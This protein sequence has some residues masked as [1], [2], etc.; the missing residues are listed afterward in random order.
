MQAIQHENSWRDKAQHTWDAELHTSKHRHR[1]RNLY[2]Q[3]TQ[4]CLSSLVGTKRRNFETQ[5]YTNCYH[6]HR[7]EWRVK[8]SE[9]DALAQ[10]AK[11]WWDTESWASRC[12]ESG[13]SKE[14]EKI[15]QILEQ[16]TKCDGKRYKV[17]LVFS[18][19]KWHLLSEQFLF[20]KKPVDFVGVYPWNEIGVEEALSRLLRS[21]GWKRIRQNPEARRYRS[22]KF[23]KTLVCTTSLSSKS[24]QSRKSEASVQRSLWI[25][26]IFTQRQPLQ[27]WTYC[28]FWL[29]CSS[30]FE[31]TRLP[32]TLKWCC[33]KRYYRKI[34]TCSNFYDETI[35]MTLIRCMSMEHMASEQNVYQ[36]GLIMLW[37]KRQ[38]SVLSAEQA[39]GN[40]K[41]LWA[42]SAKRQNGLATAGKL[43]RLSTQQTCHRL[44][45]KSLKQSGLHRP[46]CE[47]NGTLT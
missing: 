47:H 26:W 35:R 4:T 12:N 25:Q 10:Q 9:N 15:L 24:E 13:N 8:G 28:R 27:D 33:S 22:Y 29:E 43:K 19:K 39:I 11:T 21:R 31:N 6:I 5:R 2:L 36:L 32:L 18:G 40:Y 14:D 37:N 44:L 34:V 1:N 41:S 20:Y 30:G 7:P 46:H 16:T 42:I 38:K 17:G 3:R 45:V 23:G